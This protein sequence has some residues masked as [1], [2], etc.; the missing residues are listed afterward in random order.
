MTNY[1]VKGQKLEIASGQRRGRVY[2]IQDYIAESG[3]LITAI[4]PLYRKVFWF[5]RERIAR[6]GT[7]PL[8]RLLQRV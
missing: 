6:K 1:E 2:D 4:P 8:I 3:T 7:E 5:L